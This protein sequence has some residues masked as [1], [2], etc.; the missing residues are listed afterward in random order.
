V[1]IIA[2]ADTMTLAERDAFRRQVTSELKASGVKIFA[3]EEGPTPAATTLL[4]SPTTTTLILSD[5]QPPT[6]G[7]P[8]PSHEATPQMV[9]GPVATTKPPPFA[10][11]AS[12]DGT[13]VYPWGTCCVENPAHSDLSLLRSMLF[14][15][16][17]VPA[18]R[19][20]LELYERSYA[21]GRRADEK[22]HSERQ[23]SAFRR[24]RFLARSIVL[25][26]ATTAFGVATYGILNTLSPEIVISMR[27]A[28][29]RVANPQQLTRLALGYL[30]GALSAAKGFVEGQLQMI[31]SRGGQLVPP[32]PPSA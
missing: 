26:A 1:P 20:T 28:V 31:N 25:S 21:A 15:T 7:A 2:K 3:M 24:E 32:Q 8:R 10:V 5:D 14:A 16:S 12:E 13:R 11:C 4:P 9:A 22:A 6:P 29:T 17:M 23:A 18:K 19:Q 27:A 30:R